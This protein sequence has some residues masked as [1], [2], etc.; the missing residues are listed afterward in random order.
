MNF[1]NFFKYLFYLA[2]ILQAYC[3]ENMLITAARVAFVITLILTY[4]CQL[5]ACRDVINILLFNFLGY[6]Y[7]YL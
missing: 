6:C 2:N 3:S 1:G 5:F 7:T 4:P